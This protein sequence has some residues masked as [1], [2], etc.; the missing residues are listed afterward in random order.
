M[1]GATLKVLYLVLPILIKFELFF[2]FADTVPV[3]PRRATNT[4]PRLRNFFIMAVMI[5]DNSSDLVKMIDMKSNTKYLLVSLMYIT[6]SVYVNDNESGLISDFDDFLD[7]ITP[8]GKD[9]K[10]RVVLKIIG[11]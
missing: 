7:S 4:K 9:Y 2:F 10:K 6:A 11:E 8:F 3:N 1:V 5:A